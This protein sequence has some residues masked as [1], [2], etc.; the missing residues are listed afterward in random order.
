M[1]EIHVFLSILDFDPAPP[2]RVTELL[3]MEPT[4]AWTKGDAV[5]GLPRTR[6][7]HS[8]W[9]IESPLP[10]T[11]TFEDQLQALLD[12][13]ETRAGQVRAAAELYGAQITCAAY[14]DGV[15]TGFGLSAGDV[16]R[17]AALGVSMD[18]DLYRLPEHRDDPA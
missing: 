3:G 17:I 8:A 10:R 18:F 9:R 11:A 16:A 14:F 2:A 6:R 1:D 4:A 5:P 12:I 13:L 7:L 15:N